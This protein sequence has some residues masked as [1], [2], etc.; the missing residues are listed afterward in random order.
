[1]LFLFTGPIRHILITFCAC[2]DSNCLP[3]RLRSGNSQNLVNVNFLHEWAAIST[4]QISRVEKKSLRCLQN[5]F[6]K[7]KED[8]RPARAKL[9]GTPACWNG[10]KCTLADPGSILGKGSLKYGTFPCSL[11]LWEWLKEVTRYSVL[12][13]FRKCMIECLKHYVVSRKDKEGL[14][15]SLTKI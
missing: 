8:Q 11:W 12:A 7:A 2:S 9:L 6:W 15:L 1:M 4:S 10:G 3:K 14:D 13:L 5:L